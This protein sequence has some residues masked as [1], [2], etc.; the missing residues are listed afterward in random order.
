M[1][2]PCSVPQ[3]PLPVDAHAGKVNANADAEAGRRMGLFFSRILSFALQTTL[4]AWPEPE[5]HRCN[6][7]HSRFFSYMGA[8]CHADI[9]RAR[10]SC[11]LCQRWHFPARLCV[12]FFPHALLRGA[13]EART[14]VKC[15][16]SCMAWHLIAVTSFPCKLRGRR[17]GSAGWASGTYV[18]VRA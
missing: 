16:S 4:P 2:A 13:T 9:S 8:S 6:A 1:A 7:R 11:Q 12:F 14:L 3:T 17:K 18:H 10:M 15:A 5:S